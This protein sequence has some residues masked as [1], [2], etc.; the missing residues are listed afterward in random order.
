MNCTC[1]EP[2]WYQIFKRYAWSKKNLALTIIQQKGQGILMTL[3]QTLKLKL[4]KRLLGNQTGKAAQFRQQ[5][6]QSTYVRLSFI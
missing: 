5:Q 3:Q 6:I 1:C 4:R 2:A